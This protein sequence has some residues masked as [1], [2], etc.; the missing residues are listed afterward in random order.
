MS[1]SR[2]ILN[3][4]N[5]DMLRQSM[6]LLNVG[7]ARYGG[8]WHSVPHTHSYA[9]LFYVVSGKGLFQ[10]D[11]EQYPVS[12]QQMIVVNPNVVHTELSYQSFPLE[13]I[14]LGI[15]G[16]EFS[17]NETEEGRFQ[18]LNYQNR[19]GIL[20]CLRNILKETEDALP[21]FETICR[22]YMEILIV[23]LMRD[24]N[25]Q[26]TSDPTPAANRQCAVVR[27]YIDS[28][29]KESLT[30]EHLAEVAH[31]NKYYLAHS[32]KEEFGISPI[33]YQL[34]RRIEESCYLLQQTDMSLSQIARVLGFSSSSYFSQLFRK[35]KKITPSDY[36]KL[37]Q[38]GTLPN[39]TTI[40]KA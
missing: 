33:S 11:S 8:D 29:F 25:F 9:E 16:L 19:G 4:D 6:K 7:S 17:S 32:F 14:V 38:T 27:R 40:E 34:N 26:L 10:I 3:I 30:L 20:T 22:A 37:S 15:D 36:R 21:G 2:Y 24:T 35:T 13:Y 5:K 28:H 18:I 23:Q 31:V 1:H 39:K 12:A